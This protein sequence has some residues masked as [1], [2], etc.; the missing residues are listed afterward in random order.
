[1]SR[2]ETPPPTRIFFSVGEPSGDLHGANLIQALRASDPAI[3]IR[4]MGGPKMEA[5]GMQAIEDLT[6]LAVMGIVHVLL[7]LRHFWIALRRVSK[8]LD[9]WQP[10]AVVLIDFPG[11]NWWVARCARKRGI[12][13]FYYGVPQLWAWG[14]WRLKKMRK[15]VDHVLC[16]LPFE[17]E[18]YQQH[19]CKAHYVGHP[20]FDELA[21]HSLDQDLVQALRKTDQPL[22]TLLPGSRRQEVRN[23]LPTQL[24]AAAVVQQARPNVRFAIASFNAQQALMAEAILENSDLKA[25]VHVGKATELIVAADICLACSGSVSLELMYHGRPA[26]IVYHVRR[27]MWFVG[28]WLLLTVRYITLV[29]LL[30]CEDRFDL[31]KGPYGRDSAD[32]EQVPFPEYAT[33]WDCSEKVAEHVIQWLE[34]PAVYHRRVGQLEQLHG[35]LVSAGATSR[36]A[37]YILDQLRLASAESREAA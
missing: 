30:A 13:V 14:R 1:M 34:E 22:V 9:Q 35:K 28:R 8:S 16:K 33:Y 27:L 29:N 5:A 25:E 18:W 23:N 7:N 2:I 31:A 37:A 3:E 11:F 20:Y 21:S 32:P 12:P 15:L 36:A 4:G 17:A 10:D 24:R 19:G 26:V 6:R